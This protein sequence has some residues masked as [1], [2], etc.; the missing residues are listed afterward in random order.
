MISSQPLVSVVVTTKNEEKNIFNCLKSI[1]DQTYPNIEVIL[2]DNFSIDET[3]EIASR[4]TKKIYQ[5]GPERSA[6]RNFGLIKKASGVFGMF[7]DADMILS[8]TLI[9]DC[10]ERMQKNDEVIGLYIPEIILGSKLFHKVRRF[11]RPFYSGTPIDC[12]RFFSLEQFR[13][14]GGFDEE[15]F[16]SGSGEDWDL[17][18]RLREVGE[19]DLLFPKFEVED[20]L[21]WIHSVKQAFDYNE[22]PSCLFHNEESSTLRNTIEKKIYYSSA[23]SR[24][25]DKWGN[26]DTNIQIQLSARHRFL[27]LFFEK[28]NRRRTLR[29]FHKYLLFFILKSAVVAPVFFTTIVGTKMQT[30]TID[31][32]K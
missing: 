2:I 22:K 16:E 29:N 31:V 14:I 23:F 3:L 18:R 30:K 28:E 12:V 26:R 13:R 7:I 17:D 27:K 1:S 15:L 6:Q 9:G 21:S 5:V 24:Y 19:I 11:E 25:I 32:L 4:Y 8:K 20:Y 10:V